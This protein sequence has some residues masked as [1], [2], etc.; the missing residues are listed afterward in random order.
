M[1]RGS[2]PA[3]NAASAALVTAGVM[4]VA[5]P[6]RADISLGL[7]GD[8]DA[9]LTTDGTRAGT[10][11]G[12]SA[13]RL[14]F[15][16]TASAGSWSFLAEVLFETGED[17]EFRAD[18]ERLQVN[19]LYRDWL[20][21]AAGR[22]HTAIG[23]YNDG[24]HHGAFF[25]PGALRPRVV[26]FEDDGG[27]IPAHSVGVH[28]DGRLPLGDAHLRYDIDL[29]NGRGATREVVQNDHDVNRPK[30]LS[31]RVRYEPAGALDGLIVGANV[32]F[33]SIPAADAGPPG[34]AV[35]PLRE[36]LFGAH[37]AYFEHGMHAVAEAYA[38]EHRELD[39]DI[40]HRSYAGFVELG[41]SFDEIMPVVRYE[42][43]R[44]PDNGD[45][46][47]G[48][49]A[50]DGYQAL[51]LGVKYTASDNIALKL[52]TGVLLPRAA[53]SDELYSVAGQIA[54]AF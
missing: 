27:L 3:R 49:P 26:Q 44:Y 33:D 29:G 41:R 16:T 25:M 31:L 54:F 11:D 42:Y 21:L 24:F 1:A 10:A 28:A 45:P 7:Y 30:S 51:T 32:Y 50:G 43:T 23:Y 6:A 52:E 37:A 22:F 46:F 35:G 36:W 20:R 4:A 5:T 38:I 34:P 12:F 8:V 19:Y 17:N 48:T 40:T 2:A 9:G 13:A 47:F 14:E 53:G 18:V 39:T 15:F